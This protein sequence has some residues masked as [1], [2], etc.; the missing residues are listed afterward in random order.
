MK[1]WSEEAPAAVQSLQ[2]LEVSPQDKLSK[3]QLLQ[4]QVAERENLI[5]QL[6]KEAEQ[7]IKGDSQLQH[8]FAN[9]ILPF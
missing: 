1:A 6:T 4:A 5:D 7:L 9:W 2:M 3:A 8:S